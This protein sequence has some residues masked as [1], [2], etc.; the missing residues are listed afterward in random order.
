[1]MSSQQ[2]ERRS[3]SHAKLSPYNTESELPEG[4]PRRPHLSYVLTLLSGRTRS[5]GCLRCG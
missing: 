5:R 2:G 4:K 3:G 1:M